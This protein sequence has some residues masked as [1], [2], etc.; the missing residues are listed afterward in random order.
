MENL[1][2]KNPGDPNG[3]L[4]GLKYYKEFDDDMDEATQSAI[5]E[6]ARRIPVNSDD[7]EFAPRLKN[8]VVLLLRRF[9]RTA[10]MND[11][12]QAVIR[13]EEMMVA[14][15]PYHPERGARIQDWVD[16]MLAKRC[17]E[18]FQEEDLEYVTEM[19]Q[20]VGV[21]VEVNR[22]PRTY[23]YAVTCAS[24]RPSASFAALKRNC[25]LV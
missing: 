11:L 22:T 17:R 5:D 23:G 15:P 14:T 10:E 6:A 12:Q 8:L 21:T 3:Y 19:A 18:G 7:P 4:D 16:M 13:T 25:F 2:T 1:N 20:Q 24:G 9:R